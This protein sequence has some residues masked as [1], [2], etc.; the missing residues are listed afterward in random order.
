MSNYINLDD[1]LIR[2]TLYLYNNSIIRRNAVQYFI[3]ELIR[4]NSTFISF[5]VQQLKLNSQN[6]N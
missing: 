4:F 1:E 6:Y 5:V 2:S 3:E